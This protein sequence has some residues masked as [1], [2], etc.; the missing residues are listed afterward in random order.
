[1]EEDARSA[2]NE[3][4]TAHVE[5]DRAKEEVQEAKARAESADALHVQ[6]SQRKQAL[7]QQ[8]ADA[9]TTLEQL[10]AEL[11]KARQRSVEDLSA[12]RER[13]TTAI[14]ECDRAAKEELRKLQAQLEDMQ[15][16]QELCAQ[17][18]SAADHEAAGKQALEQQL[19]DA[20]TTIEQLDKEGKQTA[21]ELRDIQAER[22]THDTVAEALKKLKVAH[23]AL[24]SEHAVISAALVEHKEDFSTLEEAKAALEAA[25]AALETAHRALQDKHAALQLAHAALASRHESLEREHAARGADARRG[26]ADLG[27]VGV[28]AL[29]PMYAGIDEALMDTSEA[30]EQARAALASQLDA[31]SF[32]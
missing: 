14:G 15:A 31:V 27:S 32:V 29:E 20:K 6:C 1:M 23:E 3:L 17:M 28:G 10:H 30:L 2:R 25:H 7:E 11:D 13:A 26:L 8:L 9:N 12:E 19:A 22:L 16:T 18:E 4:R 21:R 24:E 5:R